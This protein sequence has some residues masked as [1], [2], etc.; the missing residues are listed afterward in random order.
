M[1][2]HQLPNNMLSQTCFCLIS[3]LGFSLF[4]INH[5]ALD[6]FAMKLPSSVIS[7]ETSQ[8]KHLVALVAAFIGFGHVGSYV[9]L[10]MNHP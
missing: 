7:N 2:S 3:C 1:H 10:E 9:V 5:V 4:A 6:T 8:K